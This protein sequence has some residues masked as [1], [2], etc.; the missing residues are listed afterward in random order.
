M[1]YSFDR[2]TGHFAGYDTIS[3]DYGTDWAFEGGC[4]IS[5]NGHYLYVAV[6]LN[7]YQFDLWASDISSTQTTVATWDGVIDPIIITF[8]KCQLG[9]DCKIYILGG[10][11]TRYYHI[12]HNPDE[13]GLAFN[14]E[15]RGLVLPTPS[16]ASIPYFPNYRLGPIDNPG[17]PCTATVSV[18]QPHAVPTQGIRVWPNPASSQV[19]LSANGL[20]PKGAKWMMTD[21]YGQLVHEEVLQ[22]NFS[23]K[24]IGLRHLPTGLYF[25]MLQDGQ[26]KLLD[27]GKIIKL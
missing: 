27:S 1:L 6:M 12:I 7:V 11:D 19:S 18:S 23:V 21:A 26:G 13:E 9:P 2:S 4:A 8:L 10:G 25:W 22:E 17:V 5:P 15:Q 3:I 14:L 20:L 16:G 24:E